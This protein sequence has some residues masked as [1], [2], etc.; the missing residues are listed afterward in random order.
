MR[1]DELQ[2]GK[3]VISDTQRL[4]PWFLKATPSQACAKGGRGVYNGALKLDLDTGEPAGMSK[5]LVTSSF[6]ALSQ[7]LAV[8]PD[9]IGALVSHRQL[10][11]KIQMSLD[12]AAG[13]AQAPIR[14]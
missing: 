6:R 12:A 1:P 14:R 4:L 10:A 7:A 3:P 8:Q 11:D 13:V 9:F 5:G 2:D